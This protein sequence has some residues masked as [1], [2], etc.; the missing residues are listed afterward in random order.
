MD[1]TDSALHRMIRSP[2]DKVFVLAVAMLSIVAVIREHDPVSNGSNMN[3][4][5]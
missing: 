5:D 4:F 3:I 2:Q 1:T